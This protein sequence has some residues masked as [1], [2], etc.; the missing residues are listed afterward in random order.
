MCGS[1]RTADGPCHSA[2][3]GPPVGCDPCSWSLVPPPPPPSAHGRLCINDCRCPELGTKGTWW[4][5]RRWCMLVRWPCAPRC[6]QVPTHGRAFELLN[7]CASTRQLASGIQGPC[8]AKGTCLLPVLPRVGANSSCCCG[9]AYGVGTVWA[10]AAS[11]P[12][13]CL[14]SRLRGH[15]HHA[16]LRLCRCVAR[17][18]PTPRSTAPDSIGPYSVLCLGPLC[19]VVTAP[20]AIRTRPHTGDVHARASTSAS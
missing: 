19:S 10:R 15:S 17:G 9:V 20:F 2:C 12:G 13:A 4:T 1:G 14:T 7:D 16:M 11:L 6:F 3:A 8:Q 18:T 5:R